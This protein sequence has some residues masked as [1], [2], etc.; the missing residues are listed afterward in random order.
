M[1]KQ[2][3]NFVNHLD[4][5]Q[6][7]QPSITGTLQALRVLKQPD[8]KLGANGQIRYESDIK[9]EAGFNLA[10]TVQALEGVARR[11]DEARQEILKQYAR[12]N[13]DDEVMTN[14]DRTVQFKSKAD[15]KATKDDIAQLDAVQVQADCWVFTFAEL[16]RNASDATRPPDIWEQLRWMI[17]TR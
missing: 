15:E 1:E 14:A 13:K 2:T 8:A 11:Y 5:P 7:E 16:F 6:F 10:E 9:V 12:L 17:K 4:I 3:I